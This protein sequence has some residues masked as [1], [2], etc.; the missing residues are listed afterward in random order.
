MEFKD[1]IL[2]PLYLFVIYFTALVFLQYIKDPVPKKYFLIALSLKFVGAIS[3]GL[4]Y[5]F[6]YKINGDTF[7]YFSLGSRHIWDAFMESPRLALRLLWDDGNDLNAETLKYAA[8]I[9]YYGDPASYF[10]VRVS[11]LFGLLSFH[12]Y[13]VISLFFAIFSFTGMWKMYM[14]FYKLYPHLHKQLA[15]AVFFVPSVF[16]WGSGILKDSITIGALGWTFY[17]F[18]NLFFIKK[19]M[20]KN[21][22]ILAVSIYIIKVV[23]IYIILC[24]TPAVCVWMF[25]ELSNRIKSRNTRLFLQPVFLFF[26]IGMGLMGAYKIS[27]DNQLYNLENIT[28]TAQ[29]TAEWLS[30]V[31]KMEQGS[32]YD[33]GEF[34]PSLTGM[35]K[36]APLAIW[37]TLFRPYLWEAKNLVMLM[38]AIESFIVLFLTFTT[39]RKV[40]FLKCIAITRENPIVLFALIFSFTFAFSIGIATY[41]FG[42][43]VRYKI[44]ILPFYLSAMFIIRDIGG[45]NDKKTRRKHA[46]LPQDQTRSLCLSL[47]NFATQHPIK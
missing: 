44:P 11:G 13:S 39:I 17:A 2:T 43:L 45:M 47:A 6:Y 29:I 16:F 14:T 19:N 30:Y 18:Y 4:V 42:T 9:Y 7:S 3:V 24:F 1:L 22:L 15:L 5:Q 46:P 26:A 8:R 28:N 31:S 32:G 12:T 21:L 40:G 10:I 25:I 23:K 27:E 37:V 41:N 35:L 36:K 38:S 34:D 33:L 20:V